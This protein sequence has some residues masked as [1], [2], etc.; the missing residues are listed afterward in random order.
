MAAHSIQDLQKIINSRSGNNTTSLFDSFKKQA[1]E[2]AKIP[3]EIIK[4]PTEVFKAQPVEAPAI[5]LPLPITKALP[6]P[7]SQAIAGKVVW[8]MKQ[9]YCMRSCG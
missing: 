9:R 1:E 6:Q 2:A 3:A 4:A 7:T 8:L 5:P